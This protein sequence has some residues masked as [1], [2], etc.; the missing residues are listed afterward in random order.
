[1]AMANAAASPRDLG[2]VPVMRNGY[3][4]V[5][6]DAKQGS[7]NLGK[8]GKRRTID[9]ANVRGREVGESKSGMAF[10][11]LASDLVPEVPQ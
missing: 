8:L 10:T 9:P 5:S 7:R 3:A 2:L 1:M 11:M 6:L 4:L